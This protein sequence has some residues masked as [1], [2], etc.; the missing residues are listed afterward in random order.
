M[1]VVVKYIRSISKSLPAIVRS[2]AD[3]CNILV[4]RGL[5]HV[6]CWTAQDLRGLSFQPSW[7]KDAVLL[8]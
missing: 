7:M 2:A 4:D 3:V 8:S 1:A 6:R 5:A